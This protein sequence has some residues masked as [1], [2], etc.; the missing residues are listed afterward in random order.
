MGGVG[1]AATSGEGLFGRCVAGPWIGAR[2][3]LADRI[4]SE[5]CLVPDMSLSSVLHSSSRPNARDAS[6]GLKGSSMPYHF[7]RRRPSRIG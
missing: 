2:I 6:A 1:R 3:A 7:A 4:A 5:P